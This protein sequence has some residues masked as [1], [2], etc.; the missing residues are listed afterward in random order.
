MR[1]LQVSAAGLGSSFNVDCW[2]VG[3]INDRSVHYRPNQCCTIR[4]VEF[5]D[6]FGLAASGN[7]TTMN[8]GE[9]KHPSD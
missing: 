5:H 4:F 3:Q 2:G 7:E 6:D 9:Q 8:I 1:N